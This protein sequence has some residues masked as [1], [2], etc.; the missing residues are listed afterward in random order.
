MLR[1]TPGQN[2][3]HRTLLKAEG[4][5]MGEWVDLLEA[6]C[7][8][9]ST[10]AEPLEL[11]LEGVIDVDTRGLETLRRLRRGPVTLVGCTPILLALLAQERQ[12]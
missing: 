7:G 10:G 9:M 2:R 6:E 12:P 4:R 11:D 8:R 5:L 3:S 1:L